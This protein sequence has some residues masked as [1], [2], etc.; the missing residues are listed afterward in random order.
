[1]PNSQ[2]ESTQSQ[3][4]EVTSLQELGQ[5]FQ[6]AWTRLLHDPNIRIL[7]PTELAKRW[8][9]EQ[10]LCTRLFQ[11]LS[12]TD[13][14][15]ALPKLPAITSLRQVLERARSQDVPSEL[16]QEAVKVVD[17]LDHAIHLAG[18][19]KSNLDVL[20]ARHRTHAREKIERKAK[21]QV[22]RGMASLFGI[23]ARVSYIQ[24]YLFPSEDEGWCDELAVHGFQGLRRFRPELPVLL[25]VRES[26]PNADDQLGIVMKTML[27]EEI[28]GDGLMT[29]IRPLCSD[30]MPDI[31]LREERGRLLYILN[32]SEHDLVEEIDMCFASVMRHGEPT[33]ARPNHERARFT[34]VPSTPSELAVFDLFVHK[35]VYRGQA[36]ERKILKTGDPSAMDLAAHSLDELDHVEQIE[37]LGSHVSS[38]PVS[39]APKHLD[40]V[41][42]LHDKM[43][44]TMGDFRLYRMNIR[45]PVMHVWYSMQFELPRSS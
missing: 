9:L 33:H 34:Y 11:A 25:G 17:A 14:T 10:T 28:S 37:D 36:P 16:L 1:M 5:R 20:C 6:T 27:G 42:H 19:S 38:I 31:S 41:Q 44:W 15:S 12:E 22:F 40:L 26:V 45:H 13:G 3:A 4:A 43:G 35:D 8:G 29:A 32:E 30:P 39:G 18:G 21:Q 2:S 7:R 24:V 23:Q